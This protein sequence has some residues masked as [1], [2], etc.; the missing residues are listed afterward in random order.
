MAKYDEMEIEP[1]DGPGNLKAKAAEKAPKAGQAAETKYPNDKPSGMTGAQSKHQPDHRSIKVTTVAVKGGA[2]SAG[3][4]TGTDPHKYLG[5]F[6][7]T[8]VLKKGH[9]QGDPAGALPAAP[10]GAGINPVGTA[11]PATPPPPPKP[12]SGVAQARQGV[13]QAKRSGGDVAAAKANV[14]G[15]KAHRKEEFGAVKSARKAL[16]ATP[17]GGGA[18]KAAKAELKTA[19]QTVNQDYHGAAQAKRAAGRA[20]KSDGGGGF[21]A[22]DVAKGMFGGF[23]L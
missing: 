5:H 19:K 20:K 23:G 4:C 1:P 14:A 9:N 21:G 18:R 8:N 7:N 12:V 13:R 15:Q 11:P 6:N 10:S 22:G 2:S 3:V 16:N 17:V